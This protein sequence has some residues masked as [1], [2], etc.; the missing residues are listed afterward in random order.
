MNY[1]F[2][3]HKAKQGYWAECVDLPGCS[4]QGENLKELEENATE[5]LNLY[6]DNQE[7]S[8]KVTLVY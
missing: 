2:K 5:A 8:A 1:K 3:V 4:T 6:L 7:N